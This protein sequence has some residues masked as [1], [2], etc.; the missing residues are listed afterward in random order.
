MPSSQ[1]CCQYVCM[2]HLCKSVLE[3]DLSLDK[4]LSLTITYGLCVKKSEAVALVLFSPTRYDTLNLS[5]PRPQLIL[6]NRR[7]STT[8]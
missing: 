3:F 2:Y 7:V 1:A 6:V 5:L 4:E 8:S